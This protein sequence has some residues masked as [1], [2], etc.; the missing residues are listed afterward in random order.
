MRLDYEITSRRIAIFL[1]VIALYLALQSLVMEYLIENILDPVTHEIQIQLID[2]FSVNAEQTIPTWYATLLLFMAAL[3]LANL[4][5]AH[6]AQNAPFTYYWSGLAA[7]FLY[8][9]IDEGAVIHEIA[10]DAVQAAV[11]TTGYLTFPWLI[12]AAP[13]VILFGLLYVRFLFHMPRRIALLFILAAG[14]Y[15]GGAL[16]IEAISANQY[17]LEGGVT[18]PY[19]AIATVEE[20]CE[21]LGIVVLI[22]TLLSYAAEKHISFAFIPVSHKTHETAT[23]DRAVYRPSFL[24]P[25][26]LLAFIVV[27]IIAANGALAAWVLTQPPRSQAN[28]REEDYAL[29]TL[30][31]QFPANDVVMVRLIG[32]FTGDNVAA[33]QVVAGLL[34]VYDDVLVITLPSMEASLAFAA[35]ELPFNRDEVIEILHAMGETQF[36]IFDTPAVRLLAGS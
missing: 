32:R 24:L 1:G 6:R 19:L 28:A 29:Q 14:L 20:L 7:I 36:V 26:R 2:L 17:S 4:A 10:S 31:D 8:L 11:T 18:F 22:Y 5:I 30:I 33:R 27:L 9:S 34:A 16:V 15:V 13:L 25:R 23:A 3:L 35:D 12:I 21:M